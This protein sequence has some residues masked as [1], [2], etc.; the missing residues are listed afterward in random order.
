MFRFT[1]S[2][3]FRK[4]GIS[5]EAISSDMRNR[6]DAQFGGEGNPSKL[7]GRFQ[8][9]VNETVIRFFYYTG[10]MSEVMIEDKYK[11]VASISL[12]NVKSL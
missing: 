12:S 8:V 7:D 10:E 9:R 6:F 2:D 11:E 4:Q 5:P 3:K 1:L